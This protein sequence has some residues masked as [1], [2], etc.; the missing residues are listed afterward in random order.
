M[1]HLYARLCMWHHDWGQGFTTQLIC[2]WFESPAQ[3]E[4][5][6]IRHVRRAFGGSC[7]RQWVLLLLAMLL[8]LMLILLLLIAH[9]SAETFSCLCHC[10][11]KI[12]SIARAMRL[13]KLRLMPI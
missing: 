11:T 7:Y 6:L 5:H 2:C 8:L 13:R 12:N 9:C 1:L 10:S 3:T 4:H